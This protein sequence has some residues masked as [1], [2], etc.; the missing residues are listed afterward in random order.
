[1][2]DKVAQMIDEVA[3]SSNIVDLLECVSCFIC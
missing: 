1:M 3:N 2:I